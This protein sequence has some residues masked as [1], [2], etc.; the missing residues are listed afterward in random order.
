MW[1]TCNFSLDYPYNV[2]QNGY[3]KCFYLDLRKIPVKNVQGNVQ[4]Q[5]ER[6]S[7]QILEVKWQIQNCSILQPCLGLKKK[8]KHCNLSAS[9]SYPDILW[10]TNENHT[11]KVS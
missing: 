10:Q 2:Q 6:I 4:Q 7:K 11:Y 5:E 9:L 8:A 1:L 3:E